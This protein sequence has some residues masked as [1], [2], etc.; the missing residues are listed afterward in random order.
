MK[1][2]KALDIIGGVEVAEDI[3]HRVQTTGVR[4]L[5][6]EKA[7]ELGVFQRIASMAA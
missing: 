2:E 5:D 1:H 3:K 6:Y 4:G 7:K